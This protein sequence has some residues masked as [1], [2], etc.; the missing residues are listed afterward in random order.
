M[1]YQHDVYIKCAML[2]VELK[3]NLGKIIEEEKP[4]FT[5]TDSGRTTSSTANHAFVTGS[6][7]SGLSNE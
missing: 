5:K 6:L 2:Q 1:I 7:C 4:Q 3:R